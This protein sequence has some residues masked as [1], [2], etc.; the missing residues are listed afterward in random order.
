MAKDAAKPSK[1]TIIKGTV[2]EGRSVEPGEVF[3]I[4]D[5]NR[6]AA[7]YLLARGKAVESEVKPPKGGEAKP[8]K[9]VGLDTQSG[10]ALIK[11]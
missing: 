10:D 4:T 2:F 8:N 5:A 9:A 3:D 11:R 7:R 6:H 1:I